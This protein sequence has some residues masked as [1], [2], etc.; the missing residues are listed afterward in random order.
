[1]TV[2]DVNAPIDYKVVNER[3]EQMKK[4]SVDY[5]LGVLK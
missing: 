2:E 5:I 1:M 4:Q 3:I